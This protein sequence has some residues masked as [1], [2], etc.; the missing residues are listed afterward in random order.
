ML[1]LSDLLETMEQVHSNISFEIHVGFSRSLSELLDQGRLDVAL[2]TNPAPDSRL[3]QHPIAAVPV[4]WM[5]SAENDM[6]ARHRTPHDLCD[7]PI[8]TNPAPSHLYDSVHHWFQTAGIWPSQ[9]NVC[10]TL[11]V[12]AQLASRRQGATL[13]PT[14]LHSIDEW[15]RKLVPVEAVPAIEP[16]YLFAVWPKAASTSGVVALVEAAST[17]VRQS[18]HYL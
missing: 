10:N 2:L 8:F 5:V 7:M 11:A 3:E 15:A 18:P 14:A 17:L 4:T 6:P 9:V 1:T 12:M 16:H 13:L